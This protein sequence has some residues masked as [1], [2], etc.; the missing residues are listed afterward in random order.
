[1]GGFILSVGISLVLVVGMKKGI[2]GL[3]LGSC[4]ASV[5]TALVASGLLLREWFV[6]KVEWKHVVSSLHY[7]WP[8]VPH[9]LAG[10]VLAFVDRVMLERMVPLADVG[11]YTLAI[12]LAMVMLMIVTSIKDAYAPYYF[13]L[14][15]SEP[16]PDRKLIRIFSVYVTSVGALALFGSLFA[17]DLI[18][19]LT[20]ARFHES[21]IYVPPVILGYLFLGFYFNVG[22]AIF[23]YKKTKLLPLITGFAAVCNITLNY[24]LIPRF[25]AI[26]AAW[27]TY[28]C[29]A[30]MF[31]VYY[32]VAQRVRRFAYP[33]GRIV[34]LSGLALLAVLVG[35]FIPALTLTVTLQKLGL[36]AAYIGAAYLLLFRWQSGK[37]TNGGLKSEP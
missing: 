7:G 4:I 18:M 32:V 15:S 29:Y 31:A 17:R 37:G 16:R 14:L 19:L 2:Y 25:G 11:R 26:A 23:Y 20:P 21:A 34:A 1:L 10:W 27:N 24:L 30:I 9:L 28:A 6:P 22:M 12:T 36:C 5:L 33:I 3:I 35:R 8:F 13:N